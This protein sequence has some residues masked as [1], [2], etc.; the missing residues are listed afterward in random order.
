VEQTEGH[1]QDSSAQ[2]AVFGLR[3]TVDRMFGTFARSRIKLAKPKAKN[4]GRENG[5]SS[6]FTSV[7][8]FLANRKNKTRSCVVRWELRNMPTWAHKL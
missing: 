3:E 8:N 5:T 4:T 7:V 6:V 1:L 2:Q